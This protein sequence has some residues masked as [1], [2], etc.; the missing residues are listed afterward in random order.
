MN[1]RERESIY[2]D[3]AAKEMRNGCILALGGALV[4]LALYGLAM[5]GLAKGVLW[6]LKQVH[7]IFK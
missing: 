6:F 5:A 3:R 4:C 1:T 2:E 7:D